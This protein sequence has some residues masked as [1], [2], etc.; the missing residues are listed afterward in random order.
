MSAMQTN[1]SMRRTVMN[2]KRRTANAAQATV[3]VSEP[4]L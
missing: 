1:A 3:K 4:P 2:G